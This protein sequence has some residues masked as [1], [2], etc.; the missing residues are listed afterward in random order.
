[1]I[2]AL[3]ELLVHS[4]FSGL[5][6]VMIIIYYLPTIIVGI[7]RFKTNT[8]YYKHFYAISHFFSSASMHCKQFSGIRFKYYDTRIS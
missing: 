2:Y 5:L 8:Q 7:S 4:V 3:I 1:M 6:K